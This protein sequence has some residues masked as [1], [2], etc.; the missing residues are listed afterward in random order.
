MQSPFSTLRY[1]IEA[2]LTRMEHQNYS[3]E[4]AIIE[5][6]KMSTYLSLHSIGPNK[7]VGGLRTLAAQIETELKSECLDLECTPHAGSA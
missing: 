6:V 1:E 4:D 2:G 5:L 7:T 3:I